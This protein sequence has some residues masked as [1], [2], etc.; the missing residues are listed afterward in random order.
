MRPTTTDKE[1]AAVV[2][3]VED[4]AGVR[5]FAGEVLSEIGGFKVI[6]AGNADDAWGVE[7]GVQRAQP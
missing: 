7:G 4:E 1:K 3:L 5:M 2:L 6:A